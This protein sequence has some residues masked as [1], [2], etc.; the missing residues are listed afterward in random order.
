VLN[1]IIEDYCKGLIGLR[2]PSESEDP[3]LK[4]FNKKAKVTKWIPAFAGMTIF[5]ELMM[6]LV[7]QK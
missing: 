5:C 3:V 4:I 1:N 6:R 7:L 2:H